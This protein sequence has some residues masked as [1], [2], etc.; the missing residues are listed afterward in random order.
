[1]LTVKE[2]AGRLRLSV[3]QVYALCGAGKLPHH[4]FGNGRG[5]IRVSEEQLGAYI[6]GSEVGPEPPKAPRR[7]VRLKHLEA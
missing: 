1:V 6:R 3:S 7:P 4:R 2:V 5:A